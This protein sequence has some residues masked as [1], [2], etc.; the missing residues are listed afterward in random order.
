M[1][2]N[3]SFRTSFNSKDL[4]NQDS[5]VLARVASSAFLEKHEFLEI[6]IYY[7]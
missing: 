6:A 7:S 1:F 5:D 4:G 3:Y 2:V